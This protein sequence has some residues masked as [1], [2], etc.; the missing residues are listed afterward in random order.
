[1]HRSRRGAWL[2]ALALAPAIAWV[3]L[4]AWTGVAH[5]AGEGAA[6]VPKRLVGD[7]GYWSRTQ[8]PPYGAA[9]IPF[10]KLTHINHAGIS[11][12]ADGTLVVPPLF[13]EPEL[14][15]GAH[16]AGV[17]V[18][19]LLSG[20]FTALD[21]DPAVLAALLAN[22]AA[23][24]AAHGYDG[25]DV[26][27]EYPVTDADLDAFVSL[28]QG[29]RATFPA[30]RY[31]L[32]ADVPSWGGSYPYERVRRF[33]DYFN[34]MMYDCAGPW[35][36]DGQLNSPIFP[37]PANPEP[38]ECAP[39][40]SVAA[41]AD[42]FLGVLGIAPEQLNMGTP[43]YGYLYLNVGALYGPCTDCA[44]TVLSENYGTF[45]KPRVDALGWA[46]HLDARAAVPYLLRADGSP[47]YIT[48]DDAGSTDLRVYYAVWQRGLGG[49]FM[50]ALDQ[51][52]DGH[53]QDLL[54]AMHEATRG[55][56]AAPRP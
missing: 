38:Y 11:F 54:D 37:D 29:L 46:R 4:P 8:V 3:A 27:W 50:W 41:A 43:F 55:A 56:A 26:D 33:I 9:Q 5:A 13:L 42:L 36:D 52:Y 51:D 20:D 6:P 44:H 23:F 28:M 49:S 53:S 15:A 7:Y 16:A 45:I 1:M 39:G 40:G 48:Y 2:L 31:T 34:V 14:I 35:T 19:L 24:E 30:P 10:A 25:V 32:S 22:L 18:L 47:G 17:R 21:R 12:A